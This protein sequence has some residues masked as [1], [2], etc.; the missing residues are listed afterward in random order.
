MG[1]LCFIFFVMTGTI[2]FMATLAFVRYIYGSIIL[3]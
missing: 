2:G 3:D 1:L